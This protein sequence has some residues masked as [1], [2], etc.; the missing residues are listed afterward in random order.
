MREKCA[1]LSNAEMRYWQNGFSKKRSTVVLVHGFRS[2]R[3]GLKVVAEKL[4]TKF[5]VIVPDLPGFGE[6]SGF[7]AGKHDMDNYT[8]ALREFIESLKLGQKPMVVAHSFG[9]IIVSKLAYE[10]PEILG[11]R[12]VLVCPIANKKVGGRL[13][14]L[15]ERLV[16]FDLARDDVGVATGEKARAKRTI[17]PK[18][19]A[20]LVS[21]KLVKTR[22]RALKEKIRNEQG[23]FFGGF[24]SKKAMIEG[25]RAINS[26]SVGMFARDI[27][28]RVLLVAAELDDLT[29]VQA[30]KKLQEKFER[31][32]LVIVE[33]AGHLVNYEKPD[34]I[35]RL[36]GEFLAG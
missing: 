31:A 14:K 10:A 11:K 18:L 20:E 26:G 34:E 23:R 16:D 4:A 35:A 25:V 33:K 32:E 5:N 19:V 36:A 21:S 1:H 9:A 24:S 7:R 30:Q 17:G 22:D 13:R 8:D 3:N 2:E 12:V 29:A 15:D 6:S 28:K 27:D